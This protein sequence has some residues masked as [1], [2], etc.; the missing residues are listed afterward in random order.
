MDRA[1][2]GPPGRGETG[3]GFR[4]GRG[5][6]RAGWWGEWKLLPQAEQSLGVLSWE[7]QAPGGPGAAGR[8]SQR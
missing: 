4:E 7:F 1:S 6:V 3:A 5:G 2:G 8:M